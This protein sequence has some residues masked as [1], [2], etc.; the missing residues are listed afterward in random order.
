MGHERGE[1]IQVSGR[2][3]VSTAQDLAARLC[4]L[5]GAS[6]RERNRDIALADHGRA[7]LVF[8]CA[9]ALTVLG[10]GSVT[11]ICL[12]VTSPRFSLPRHHIH[13]RQAVT[14]G[15]GVGVWDCVGAGPGG[16]IAVECGRVPCSLSA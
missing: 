1:E 6:H 3:T 16:R 12:L 4:A 5:V 13:N 8:F 10:A 9:I 15:A 14:S 11:F 2:V 7:P